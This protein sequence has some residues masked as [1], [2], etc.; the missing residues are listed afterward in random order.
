MKT[1]QHL[2]RAKAG[3]MG[4]VCVIALSMTSCLKDNDDNYVAPQAAAV[5]IVNA[6]PGSQPVDVYFDQNLATPYAINYGNGQDYVRAYTGK[7]TI[8]FYT[9]IQQKLKSD[10]T[11]FLA[12]KFYTT[13]LTGTSASPELVVVK[14]TLAQPA[15]GKA[16][17]RLVNVSPDAPAINL[18]IRNGA[19]LASSRAYKGVSS[20][21]PVQGNTTYTFDVVQTGTST[22]LASIADVNLKNNAVYTVWL[23]GLATATD[24]NKLTAGIQINAYYN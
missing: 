21:V 23:R 10:T 9:G 7:R 16:S 12:N 15:A 1:V 20:F 5:S 22:V 14:D 2:L 11:T 17:I 19:T 24:A 18:V 3:I 4:L 6:L 8:T 13:Y